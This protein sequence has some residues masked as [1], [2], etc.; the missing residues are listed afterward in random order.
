MEQWFYLNYYLK[1]NGSTVYKF[2]RDKHAYKNWT[3]LETYVLYRGKIYTNT[4]MREMEDKE[5]I[6]LINHLNSPLYRLYDF[7]MKL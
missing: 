6:R 1:P 5:V 4:T 3:L 7:F 2:V